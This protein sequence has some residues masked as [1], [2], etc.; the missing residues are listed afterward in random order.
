MSE[1][2]IPDG[3]PDSNPDD[4][5]DKKTADLKLLARPSYQWYVVAVLTIVYVFNF[6]DRQILAIL[7]QSIKDELLISDSAFGFLGGIAFAINHSYSYR[8]HRDHDRNGTPNIGT[9]MFTPYVRIVP[10]HLTII[11]GSTLSAGMGNFLFGIGK[12]I[13]DAIMHAVE[14]RMIARRSESN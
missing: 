5:A 8:Y 7:G 14:H 13:A 6:I 12:T 2:N 3:N 4:L 11:F 9:M 1:I 10:M